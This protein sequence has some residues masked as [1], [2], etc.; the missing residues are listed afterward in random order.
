MKHGDND[1]KIS[2][3]APASFFPKNLFL[4]SVK[5]AEPFSLHIYLHS[6][7]QNEKKSLSGQALF[8]PFTNLYLWKDEHVHPFFLAKEGFGGNK[9]TFHFHALD[10]CV[11]PE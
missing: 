4:Y 3:A 2:L 1:P 5:E 10:V 7:L 8:P 9:C 11:M 6:L